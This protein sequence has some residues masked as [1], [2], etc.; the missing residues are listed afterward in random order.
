MNN[1]SNTSKPAVQWVEITENNNAQ[2]LDNFLITHLKGVP[3]SR[4]YRIVRKGEVRVNK[5]RVD[6]KYRLITG[7]IVRIPPV[8]MENQDAQTP[9]VSKNL[10]EN[11][12]NAILFED[13][14]LL[15]INKPSG[16]AVH[17]GSGIDSGIIEGF[18]T[19][20][21]GYT[22][23]EL[24]HRLD[25]DTSGCLI[26]AK[27]R[28]TLRAL[29]EQF[30]NDTVAK[31]YLALFSG[32]W[33]HKR[34]LVNEPLLK[35]ISKGGERIVVISPSGKASETLFTR[36]KLYKDATL[37]EARPKTGRTHQI[38]VHAAF[39]KHPILGDDRYGTNEINKA[40]RIRGYKGMFLHAQ[41]LEFQHPASGNTVKFAAPL[42]KHF[43]LFIDNEKEI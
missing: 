12:K 20:N 19:L 22:F 7:D 31:T 16:V 43:N 33:L 32:Q 40:F 41:T 27:K 24:V 37:V 26:I 6:V 4:I 34:A 3:K 9:S 35:N 42:P 18:R 13:Q 10:C 15:V 2:R 36:L 29:H 14:Y 28:S 39:L 5:G 21:P 17:G 30:R 8:R 38:R 25:R 11:L 1:E 23:L